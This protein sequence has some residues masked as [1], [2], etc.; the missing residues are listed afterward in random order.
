MTTI[1][2]ND[3][4][5]VR[6]ESLVGGGRL[7][8]E[9]KSGPALYLPYRS[10]LAVKFSEVARARFLETLGEDPPQTQRSL[11]AEVQALSEKVMESVREGEDPPI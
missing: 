8:L 9:R 11:R 10:S 6:A 2:L 7:E 1:A 5:A 4:S 3:L